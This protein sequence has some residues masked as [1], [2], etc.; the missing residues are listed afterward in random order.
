MDTLGLHSI[1][2]VHDNYCDNRD[3]NKFECLLLSIFAL[4][5]ST[6]NIW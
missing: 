5:T 1:R 4:A 3:E 2:V 6:E